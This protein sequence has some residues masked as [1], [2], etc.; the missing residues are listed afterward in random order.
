MIEELQPKDISLTIPVAE[1]YWHRMC[2]MTITAHFIVWY[3]VIISI[4][5]IGLIFLINWPEEFI[6]YGI[7]SY[8][9]YFLWLWYVVPHICSTI[10][11]FNQMC[12]YLMLRFNYCNDLLKIYS[13]I[14][15]SIEKV[16]KFRRI[17]QNHDHICSLISKFNHF[18]SYPL[19][20]D[21][22]MYTSLSI[23]MFYLA[24]FSDIVLWFRMFLA[25]LDFIL[26]I[27]LFFLF[28]SSAFVTSKVCK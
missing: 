25:S 28:L 20:L 8:L 2:I 13:S 26:V 27:C 5:P 18:W 21:A 3:V 11:I 24:F 23:L 15:Y 14:N 7:F 6:I 10:F 9:S 19:L 22:I 16:E 1:K 4:P 17:L 12:Y